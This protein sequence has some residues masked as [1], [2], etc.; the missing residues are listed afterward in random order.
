MQRRL[1][2]SGLAAAVL[3]CAS[4]AATSMLRAEAPAA[5]AGADPAPFELMM[6]DQPGCIYCE[7]WEAEIAPA[8]P[9]TAEGRAAP[10]RRH[11][12]HDPLPED[13]TLERPA[14][15]TPTFVLLRDGQ[16][17]GRIEGY[18]GEDFFWGVLAELIARN[19]ENSETEPP[20]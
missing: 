1:A 11:G 18:P 2:L 13:V 9:K 4:L 15:F 7:R 16:E 12:L 3:V 19:S 14:L 6:V 10:L 17:V 8:Y 5:E 20:A